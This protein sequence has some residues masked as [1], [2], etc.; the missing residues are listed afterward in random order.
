MRYR[1]F[2][3]KAK[4]YSP[5]QIFDLADEIESHVIKGFVIPVQAIFDAGVNLET[6]QD[7]FR[8]F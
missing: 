4:Q 2:S 7:L 6:M 3:P 1:V 5:P 8:N